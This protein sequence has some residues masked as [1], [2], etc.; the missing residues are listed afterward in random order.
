VNF[1]VTY[2]L[3]YQITAKPLGRKVQ[4]LDRPIDAII[5]GNIHFPF[6]HARENS[7]RLD[8]LFVE[9]FDL[10][11]HQGDQWSY[12]NTDAFHH[13][14]RN[15]EAYRF[16]SARRHQ[17]EGIPPGQYRLDDF[18]LQ[19]PERLML[20]V[21]SEYIYTIHSNGNPNDQT[22]KINVSPGIPAPIPMHLQLNHPKR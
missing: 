10:I 8:S 7:H 17:R 16:T 20:P 5:K 6:G 2:P 18:F 11:F 1:H 12:H 4:E 13:Q 22:Y 19:R 15:L 3:L 21:S 9:V 14:R